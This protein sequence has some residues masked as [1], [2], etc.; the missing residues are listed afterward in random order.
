MMED[1]I[2]STHV[3]NKGIPFPTLYITRFDN[4]HQHLREAIEQKILSCVSIVVHAASL[5]MNGPYQ[6]KP[7]RESVERDGFT[8]KV[9]LHL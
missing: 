3:V 8:S 5:L 1:S 9:P 7:E 2:N 4:A 6:R